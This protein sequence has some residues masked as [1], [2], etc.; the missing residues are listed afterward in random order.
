MSYTFKSIILDAAD[1]HGDASYIG[2]LSVDFWFE[3]SKITNIE[4]TDFVAY[5]TTEYSTSYDAAMAFD[6][7]LPKTGTATGNRWYSSVGNNSIQRLICVFNSE[8]EFD[9][10]RINNSHHGGTLTDRGIN[11]VKIHGSTDSI[12]DTTYDAAIANST[13]I[14]D[15]VF[16]EHVGTDTEDEEILT[17][18]VNK[19]QITIDAGDIDSDLTHF[20]L[21]IILNSEEN[22]YHKTM[23][24]AIQHDWRKLKITKAD[25]SEL[26]VEKVHWGGGPGIVL[27]IHSDTYDGSVMYKD[28][29][30]YSHLID[31]AVVRHSTDQSQWGDSSIDLPGNSGLVIAASPY[32]QF[33]G[34]FTIHQWV[35]PTG[36]GSMSLVNYDSSNNFHALYL[37]SS[38]S[39]R[40]IIAGANNLTGIVLTADTWQHFALVRN[41][42]SLKAYIDGVQSGTTGTSSGTVGGV[43]LNYIG[44]STS[45]H[46]GNGYIDEIIVH[47]GEALWTTTFTPPTAAMVNMYGVLWAS[48]DDFVISS[49]TDTVLELEYG[50]TPI[51]RLEFFDDVHR[52]PDL[53]VADNGRTLSHG[54]AAVDYEQVICKQGRTTGKWYF[55]VICTST[56]IYEAIGVQRGYETPETYVGDTVNGWGFMNTLFFN[57]TTVTPTDTF[58]TGDIVGVAV[59]M[60]NGY[61]WWSINGTWVGVSGDSPNPVTG[62]DPAYSNLP[63]VV[64]PALSMYTL[65]SEMTACFIESHM[66]YSIPSGFSAWCEDSTVGNNIDY[67]SSVDNLDSQNKT[68]T[69]KSIILDIADNHGGSYIGVRSIDFWLNGE[70]LTVL[71]A[72]ITAYATTEYSTGQAEYAFDTSYTKIGTGTN[73]QW[74]SNAVTTNQRLICVFDL[75]IVFDTIIIN[76][77]HGSGTNTDRGSQNVVINIS[78]DAITDTTYDAAIANSTELFDDVFREHQAVDQEH[79]QVVYVAAPSIEQVDATFL[80]SSDTTDGS[81]VFQDSSFSGHGIEYAGDTHHEDTEKQFGATSIYFDGTEDYL[82]IPDST[83]F[84]F[85]SGD[86]TIDFCMQRGRNSTREMVFGQCDSSGNGS[87]ISMRMEITAGDVVSLYL[88]NSNKASSYSLSDTSNFYHIAWVRKG[89]NLLLFVDGTLE[90]TMSIGTG[91]LVDSSTDFS[92]GRQGEYA[93]IYYQGYIDEFRIVKGTAVWTSNFIPPNRSYIRPLIVS[94]NVWKSDFK[95]VYH[96]NQDPA[97][98]VTGGIKE[99]TSNAHHGTSS[100]M[101]SANLV[102]GLF[103]HGFD[104]DGSN[105][106]ID[107]NTLPMIDSTEPF[108]ISAIVN[109]DAFTDNYPTIITT[110]TDIAENWRFVFS[111]QA[112]YLDIA[113]GSGSATFANGTTGNISLA[114]D[115]DYLVTLVYNGS[116]ASTLSNYT[117]YVDGVNKTLSASSAFGTETAANTRIGG[118]TTNTMWDG[119]ISEVT[120]EQGER[121]ATWEAV[122]NLAITNSLLAF[123]GPSEGGPDPEGST[124]TPIMMIIFT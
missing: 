76:N 75:P 2:I 84:T 56:S 103:G 123:S 50:A 110:H 15:G 28:S 65:T 48:R 7:S 52:G 71:T 63:D 60:D 26:Y 24:E 102:E 11:N 79:S 118:Y 39:G 90:D 116:G 115:T 122:N 1:N 61:I 36:G 40:V 88:M 23:F 51:E 70:K 107:L 72:D 12:T 47:N 22:E 106:S 94:E 80:L 13:L 10:I 9:E 124:A 37:D 112:G 54:A 16:A 91:S 45:T 87:S 113:F 19:F 59:D 108:T 62:T 4:T 109:L 95:A 114:V 35:Y 98:A 100:G 42:T 74:L 69:A 21:L 73:T 27:H 67:V 44:R 25:N 41:G 68:V 57:S 3:G 46:Y 105:D 58:N 33:T 32:L 119:L 43:T 31:G 30:Q 55:E 29:S 111:N 38:T 89:S 18:L 85:G 34:D 8:T 121:S 120:I 53:V 96:M 66:N 78:S 99:S 81:V 6:T 83:D 5:A 86:W 117:L 104:F 20:P 93:G 92:I 77:A 82:S 49:S 64:Y 14:F 97:G 17:L 101:T